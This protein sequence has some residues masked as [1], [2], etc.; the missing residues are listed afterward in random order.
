MPFVAVRIVLDEASE[1]LPAGL[2]VID[3]R[4]DVRFGAAILAAAR[5]PRAVLQLARQRAVCERRLAEVL[6]LML[7]ADA[8][9]LPPEDRLSAAP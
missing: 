2:D 4:G 9:G 5:H 8:L 1:T 3:E 6:P 7:R